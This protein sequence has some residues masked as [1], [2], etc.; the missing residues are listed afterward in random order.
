MSTLSPLN[1]PNTIVLRHPSE[2]LEL[3]LPRGSLA[4]LLMNLGYT[5]VAPETDDL[6]NT[7]TDDLKEDSH[8]QPRFTE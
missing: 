6:H 3:V 5:E 1:P 2:A 4:N 7:L 8:D